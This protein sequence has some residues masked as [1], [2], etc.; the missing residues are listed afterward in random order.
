MISYAFRSNKDLQECMTMFKPYQTASLLA[1]RLNVND[2]IH[3]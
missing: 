2:L 3:T 1:E